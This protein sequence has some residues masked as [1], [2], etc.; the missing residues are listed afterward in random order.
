R[1][2]PNREGRAAPDRD[3]RGDPDGEQRVSSREA[4]R[5]GRD[6]GNR[7]RTEPASPASTNAAGSSIGGLQATSSSA[8][9]RG[10]GGWPTTGSGGDS[11]GAGYRSRG[12][13][14]NGADHLSSGYPERGEL[15][16]GGGPIAA[17]PREHR[18]RNGRG[19]TPTQ[20]D[21]RRRRKA[22]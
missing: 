4:A 17:L 2:T 7:E 9:G 12:P 13:S 11:E 3:R 22:R 14:S 6:D 5:R 1:R 8:E 18:R 21:W 19:R 16:A 15:R 20:R 10:R